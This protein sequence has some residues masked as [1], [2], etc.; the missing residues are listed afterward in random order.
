M[1]LRVGILGCGRIAGYFHAP[2]LAGMPGVTVVALADTSAEGR[3]ALAAHA[4]G[5][6]HLAD[7]RGAL[8]LGLCD[9]VAI[10]LPPALHATAAVAALDAGLHV[11]VEK[12]MAL[13]PDEAEAMIAARDRSG[14]VAMMG[15]NFRFHPLIEDARRRISAGELGQL[16]AMRAQFASARRTL[17]GWKAQPGAGG[18]ALWDLATHDLDLIAHLA[19]SDWLPDALTAHQSV[20]D[21]GSAAVVQGR[22]TN[23]TLAQLL[24]S[25]T[26]GASSRVIDIYGQKGHLTVDLSDATPRRLAVGGQGRGARLGARLRALGPAELRHRPGSEPSFAR[27]LSAFVATV[28]DGGTA[29]PGFEDGRRA[30]ALVLAAQHA[31]SST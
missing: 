25:Q 23:G 2:I 6:V 4:P 19:G 18:D 15:L 22:L 24:A 28:R 30:V 12:P 21:D 20:T 14:R 1:T 9:A 17:P 29:S 7:W 16:V 5:A 3:R 8:D 26:T 13:T 27:A 11:Y 10:C 31:A